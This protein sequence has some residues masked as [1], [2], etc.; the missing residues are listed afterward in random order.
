M[1]RS[2]MDGNRMWAH[3]GTVLLGFST[4]SSWLYPGRFTHSAE[5]T[6]RE[7]AIRASNTEPLSDLPSECGS[8]YG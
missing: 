6:T 1:I 8:R 7:W 2:A 4:V 3:G 5:G